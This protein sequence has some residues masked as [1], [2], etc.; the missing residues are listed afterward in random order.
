M[1]AFGCHNPNHSDRLLGGDTEGYWAI[2]VDKEYRL[3]EGLDMIGDMGFELVGIQ[4]T[5]LMHGGEAAG[6]Y[7]PSYLYIFKRP[8]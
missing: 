6:W 7:H 2:L 3:Q 1:R 5:S 4:P 8:I